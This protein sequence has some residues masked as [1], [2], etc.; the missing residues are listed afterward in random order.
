[1]TGSTEGNICSEIHRTAAEPAVLVNCVPFTLYRR[2]LDIDNFPGHSPWP[3]LLV[4]NRI[5]RAN[6][7]AYFQVLGIGQQPSFEGCAR[8]NGLDIYWI[9]F[10][11]LPG[12][13]VCLH[14]DRGRVGLLQTEQAYEGSAEV[15]ARVT[16]WEKT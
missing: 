13:A 6:R 12:R 8:Q 4:E 2:N 14:S 7:G 11:A 1:V 5:V 3:D 10:S 15:S 16:V 9:P